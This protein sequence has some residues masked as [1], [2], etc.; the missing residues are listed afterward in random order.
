MTI[1]VLALACYPERMA[2]TRFRVSQ[3]IEPL[4]NS[5]IEIELLPL[6]D[7]ALAAT[8]Y[9]GKR[10]LHKA[11]R[12]FS[13]TKRLISDVVR[14]SNADIVFV[15]RE[16]ALVGPPLVEAL[17][18]RA[19]RVPVVLDIDD[20][21]WLSSGR[22]VRDILRM[23]WKTSWLARAAQHI[24]VG[25][26]SLAQ[27]ARKQC[28][29]VTV[30]Q[31]VVP[32]S[33]WTPRTEHLEGKFVGELPIIGW[34]GTHSTAPS[35]ALVLPA[36]KKLRSEG[37]Q[38]GFRVAGAGQSLNLHGFD[39]EL[40]AW[41]QEREIDMFRDIDIGIAPIFDGPWSEGKCAFKQIQYMATGVPHVSSW[42]G[43]ARDF[44]KHNE[45]ALVARDE[46]AWYRSIRS[47]LE[48]SE[49]RA[50]LAVE[51][52]SLVQ[53]ELCAE[54]MGERLRDVLVQTMNKS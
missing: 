48:D 22:W 3:F 34:I 49:L 21:T 14:R 42:V 29:N 44:L 50:R 15:Q 19:F 17:A 13:C 8:F 26:H 11:R 23:P 5:G 7:D 24:V 41:S 35:L 18:S 27:W 6:F 31:T 46:Q 9:D 25:S 16:A 43:G 1:R 38:F 40:L 51:G 54:V 10:P 45:N 47:L 28:K 33:L 37:F 53:R 30:I 52:R 12:V 36:L 2:C 32:A 4:R 20:A 39:T